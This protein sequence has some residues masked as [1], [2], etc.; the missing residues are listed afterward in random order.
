MPL[1][2][3]GGWTP[4]PWDAHDDVDDADDVD[5]D[6]DVDGADDA[7]DDAD[8]ANDDDDDPADAD[9]D[10]DDDDADF[11]RND[12]SSAPR[13]VCRPAREMIIIMHERIQRK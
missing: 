3:I 4:T 7:D 8:D 9:D 11:L 1:L 10:A 13:P 6:D 12:T 5:L 2:A